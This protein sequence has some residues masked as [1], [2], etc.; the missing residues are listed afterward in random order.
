MHT[1]TYTQEEQN[2]TKKL[3]KYKNKLHKRS[4]ASLLAN[5]FGKILQ[6]VCVLQVSVLASLCHSTNLF[7]RRLSTACPAPVVILGE[8]KR[9]VMTIPGNWNPVCLYR[10][11]SWSKFC[12]W[13]QKRRRMS[14]L[15]EDKCFICFQTDYFPSPFPPHLN[16]CHCISSTVHHFYV[17]SLTTPCP[18]SHLP[19]YSRKKKNEKKNKTKVRICVGELPGSAEAVLASLLLDYWN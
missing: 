5:F 4:S 6:V 17:V 18:P 14:S 7:L 2:K 9:T 1:R 3:K 15:C 8:R 13:A 16:L 11:D 19:R 10:S 12:I